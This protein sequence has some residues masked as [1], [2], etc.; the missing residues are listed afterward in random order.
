MLCW[1]VY[2]IEDLNIL[3]FTYWLV[4]FILFAQSVQRFASQLPITCI[5]EVVRLCEVFQPT[6]SEFH[7]LTD[8]ELKRA[9]PKKVV[10]LLDQ[11]LPHSLKVQL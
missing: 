9:I 7:Q 6:A 5:F 10:L 8:V 11:F 4:S 1:A 2:E 3:H